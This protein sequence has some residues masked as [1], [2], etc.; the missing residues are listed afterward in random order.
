M[1]LRI[2]TEGESFFAM[3]NISLDICMRSEW[4][5]IVPHKL[6]QIVIERRLTEEQTETG[7]D[8]DIVFPD[9]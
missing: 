3:L 9:W 6:R 2:P 1:N 5:P 8:E 4:E 7:L